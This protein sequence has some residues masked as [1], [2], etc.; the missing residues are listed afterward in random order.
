TIDSAIE[1]AN[2]WLHNCNQAIISAKVVPA[3][4]KMRTRRMPFTQGTRLINIQAKPRL[5]RNLAE[6][7][8]NAPLRRRI[9]DRVAAVYEKK[10]NFSFRSIFK[11]RLKV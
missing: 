1:R 6:D 7:L 9:V 4:K 3:L 2:G 11:Q 8:F 5:K 10:T